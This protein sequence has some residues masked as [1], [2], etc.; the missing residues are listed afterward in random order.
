MAF[1]SFNR[2]FVRMKVPLIGINRHRMNVDGVGVTTLVAF[3]GCPLR[4]RYCLNPQ[5]VQ[6]EGVWGMLSPEELFNQVK[7]DNLYFQATG[8]GITFG[9]GEPC[10][11]SSFI[12]EFC[13]LIPKEW[14]IT[15]ETS[16]NVERRHLV[17]L[18]PLV[19]SYIVDV[20]DMHPDIYRNYT[21]RSNRR[22]IGNLKWMAAQ[23]MAES[24]II[25]LPL[26]PDYNTQEDI[27][28]SREELT[29]WGFCYFDDFEYIKNV[30]QYKKQ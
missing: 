24:V 16:L 1:C 21:G 27:L 20:K 8:G 10:L 7:I 26:I 11:Q 22:V 9:G 17:T 5:C 15:I 30:N 12:Q 4:C 28:R 18:L 13:R 6:A 2:N 19:N 23:G 25:R 14:N 29:S 3:H